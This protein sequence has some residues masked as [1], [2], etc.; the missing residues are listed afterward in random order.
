MGVRW[1]P[2]A[3]ASAVPS[4]LRGCEETGGCASGMW[5]TPGAM[6]QKASNVRQKRLG[7][8]FYVM[9]SHGGFV[10]LLFQK[11]KDVGG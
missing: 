10:D 6:W 2:G 5:E 1:A 11:T 9:G 8:I 4:M 7:F 3:V